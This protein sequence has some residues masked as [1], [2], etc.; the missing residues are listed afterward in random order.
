MNVEGSLFHH[1]PWYVEQVYEECAGKGSVFSIFSHEERDKAPPF[2][3]NWIFKGGM[4]PGS[5]KKWIL[6]QH[7]YK[8]LSFNADT[9]CFLSSC[10]CQPA[11]PWAHQPTSKIPAAQPA[12]TSTQ[13]LS[14]M[15][16]TQG[17]KNWGKKQQF[18][19]NHVTATDS[20]DSNWCCYLL[21]I[22]AEGIRNT[23]MPFSFLNLLTF[24]QQK[25][26][27]RATY[28]QIMTHEFKVT[29]PRKPQWN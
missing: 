9:N 2:I 1:N 17:H 16:Q 19:P 20:T 23:E 4:T 27:F 7:R 3:L 11:C 21:F 12:R 22:L 6:L 18:P 25:R 26:A 10:L 15:F 13:Y 28:M 8:L 5:P 29:L 24:L 14:T